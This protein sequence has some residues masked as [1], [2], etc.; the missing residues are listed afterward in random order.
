M[1]TLKNEIGAGYKN[2]GIKKNCINTNLHSV[3]VL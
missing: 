3:V 1:T 2:L